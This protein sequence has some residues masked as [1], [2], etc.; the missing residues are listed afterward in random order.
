MSSDE[1]MRPNDQFTWYQE[2]DPALRSTIVAV[3]WLDSTPDWERLRSRMEASGE[4]VPKFRQKV[5]ESPAGLAPPRWV[6]DPD[7]DLSW[8]LRRTGA[9][10]PHTPASVIELAR[11][12][13]MS[14]FDRTRP[15]WTFTLIEGLEDGRAALLMKIHHSITDGQGAMKLVPTLF[16]AEP[17]A[18]PPAAPPGPHAPPAES[19]TLLAALGY[20]GHQVLAA[21]RV[22][23]GAFAAGMRAIGDPVGAVRATAGTVRSIG[24]TVAPVREMLS[25][26]MRERGLGRDL[27]VLTVNLAA[28]KHAAAAVPGATLNDAF[29]TGITGGLHR[30]HHLRGAEPAELRVTMPISIRKSGDPA[31]SNRVTLMRFALPVSDPDPRSRMQRI[32]AQSRKAQAQRALGFTDAIAAAL[33]ILPAAVAGGMLK[34]IDFLASNVAGPPRTI[35]LAG[36]EVTAYT[37]FG[38]T[39]GSAA[40]LTLLSYAGT[41]HIGMTIDNAAVPD[42]AEFAQCLRAGFT[43]TLKLA[44]PHRGAARLPVQAGES[45]RSSHRPGPRQRTAASGPRNTAPRQRTAGPAVAD[46]LSPR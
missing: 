15:L 36:A 10:A 22:G 7:F 31:A 27:E 20:R 6:D 12:A 9:P 2:S 41:C 29:L 40:N 13:A 44:T 3:V 24:A 45:P 4:L 18:G 46:H 16:D 11:V 34:K 23:A 37:P 26:V 25:P 42:S 5:V 21:A 39:M 14:G 30:Y 28:L 8:H 32:S 38:P 1:F 35:Y 33:D 17:D 43:E 19:S